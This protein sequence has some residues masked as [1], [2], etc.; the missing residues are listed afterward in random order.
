MN[1]FKNIWGSVTQHADKRHNIL[2]GEG[3]DLSI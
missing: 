2:F 3:L 1:G